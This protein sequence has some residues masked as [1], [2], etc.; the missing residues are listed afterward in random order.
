MI[1]IDWM[2]FGPAIAMVSGALLALCADLLTT[3]RSFVL[4]W[5]PMIAGAAGA[6]LLTHG[7]PVGF[8]GI[9]S[10]ATLVVVVGSAVLHDDKAMPPGEFQFLIGSA[11]AGGLVIVAATDVVTLLLGLE[12]LT[13]PSIALAGLRLGDRRAIGAA[14]TFFLTSVVAT[15]VTL[16][17]IALVYGLTGSLQYGH[18][19]VDGGG[20]RRVALTVGLVLTL[21]GFLFKLGAVPFH[22]WVPD[23]Y[24]GASPIVAGFLSSVSKAAALGALLLLLVDGFGIDLSGVWQPLI[25][26]I[27]A[28][29]MTIGN[30]GALRQQDGVG[31]LAWSS[32]AQVGFLLAPVAG[33]FVFGL[34]M[35][36]TRVIDSLSFTPGVQYLAVYALASAVA[37][38]ALAVALKRLGS[39][40]YQSL[41]GFGRTNPLVG[42]PLAF[43]VLTL[44]GFPPAVIG[45]VTKYV[46][47]VPVVTS[48]SKLLAI[49]MAINVML[50]LR[51]YLKFVAVLFATPEPAIEPPASSS[52]GT[53]AAVVVVI[54][55]AMALV[56]MS[57]WP[58]LV[59]NHVGAVLWP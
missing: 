1:P 13:L 59:L 51:Y 24:R 48:G 29:T 44:A 9:I 45:L 41:A 10:V 3:K 55:G 11:A 27:A 25:V 15:A 58:S 57:V 21:I 4:S 39:T 40:S 22:T 31:V 52:A 54:L 33:L 35:S 26:L 38:V 56:A 28:V 8:S 18:L 2:A 32:V 43:A 42:I 50:V 20:A 6:V 19:N 7:L 34:K 14:W 36:G 16:M 53:R 47:F 30:L 49:V 37:F 12:L 5:V 23:A 46:V 17:G